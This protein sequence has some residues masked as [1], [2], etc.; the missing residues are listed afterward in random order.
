MLSLIAQ[1]VF[2]PGGGLNL[3]IK[4]HKASQNKYSDN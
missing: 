1:E 2:F 4:M 3:K